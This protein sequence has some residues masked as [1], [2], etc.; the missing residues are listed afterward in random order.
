MEQNL[1]ASSTHNTHMST[2]DSRS[3]EVDVSWVPLLPLRNVTLRTY[4]ANP[5]A[6][7]ASAIATF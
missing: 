2:T 7:S 4:L 6:A 1:M 3:W 5:P